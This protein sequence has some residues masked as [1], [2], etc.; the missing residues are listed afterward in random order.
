MGQVLLHPHPTAPSAL[1]DRVSVRFER[2]GDRLWLRYV[3]DGNVD[4][5]LWPHPATPGRADEL[6]RHTCFEAFVTTPDGY[7]EYNLSPSGRWASYRF[8][9]YRDGMRNA[10]EVVEI[11]G[12]DGGCDMAALEAHVP[13]PPGPCRIGLTAVI[14]ARDGAISYWALAHPSDNPDFHNSDSFVL[15]LP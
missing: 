14:E 4:D 10:P 5:I 13:L 15:D 2:E 7:L 12:M 8:D 3:V 1:I 6:W 9:G 11:S